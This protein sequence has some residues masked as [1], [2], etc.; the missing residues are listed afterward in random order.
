[1]DYKNQSIS[2]VSRIYRNSQRRHSISYRPKQDEAYLYPN[3]QDFNIGSSNVH[4][5]RLAPAGSPDTAGLIAAQVRV[6]T[7][8]RSGYER[9]QIAGEFL[10]SR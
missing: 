4:S 3:F 8:H 5:R 7:E 6:P 10:S 2:I 9:R 1:M